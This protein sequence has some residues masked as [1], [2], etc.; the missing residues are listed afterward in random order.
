VDTDKGTLAIIY[1]KESKSYKL[2]SGE[3][4]SILKS[5]KLYLIKDELVVCLHDPQL[6]IL[7]LET[8]SSQVVSKLKKHNPNDNP[9]VFKFKLKS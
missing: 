4:A 1:S 3:W 5:A 7:P 2:I 9:I 6:E 8:L